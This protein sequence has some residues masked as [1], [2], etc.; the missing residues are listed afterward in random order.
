MAFGLIASLNVI[1]QLCIYF[2]LQSEYYYLIAEKMC[3]IK[4]DL[5]EKR[6]KRRAQQSGQQSGEQSG[7][8]KPS[9][10]TLLSAIRSANTAE[11]QSQTVNMLKRYP[12]LM[13]NYLEYRAKQHRAQQMD[14]RRPNN[15]RPPILTNPPDQPQN[16]PDL[17]GSGTYGS[18]G[19][20]SN[21]P[22]ASKTSQEEP[23]E[24][25]HKCTICFEPPE[26][27]F[28]FLNCGHLPF[29][30]TCSAK[31]MKERKRCPICREFVSKRQRAFFQQA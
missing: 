24:N 17:T 18:H 30:D 12:K 5:E 22:T 21:L 10:N 9:L 1:S 26:P 27:M 4:K 11:K 7:G 31:I 20:S 8:S 19:C 14:L 6:Q 13:A 3:K 23:K 16:V 28:M 2:Q 25:G 29:C 15:V